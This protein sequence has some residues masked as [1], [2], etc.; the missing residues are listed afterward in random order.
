M[1]RSLKLLTHTGFAAVALMALLSTGL[2][3]TASPPAAPA[4]PP[5]MEDG[6]LKDLK[7]RGIGN[8]NLKGRISSI[9]ALE[10]LERALAKPH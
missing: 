2:T 4:A 8:A 6:L 5:Q 3:A 7:W 9:D 10:E 1:S